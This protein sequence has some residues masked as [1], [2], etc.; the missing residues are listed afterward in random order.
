[1]VQNPA[2]LMISSLRDQKLRLKQPEPHVV[3]IHLHQTF[4]QPARL[5]QPCGRTDL[6]QT[7]RLVKLHQMHNTSFFLHI[8]PAVKAASPLPDRHR[9]PDGHIG[10]A[11]N[12]L[13]EIPSFSAHIYIYVHWQNAAV[14]QKIIICQDFLFRE[15][16]IAPA[17]QV[18]L[19]K[20]PAIAQDGH[21]PFHTLGITGLQFHIQLV[22]LEKKFHSLFFIDLDEKFLH[23]L[24]TPIVCRKRP[25]VLCI[26]GIVSG[27]NPGKARGIKQFHCLPPAALGQIR[28]MEQVFYGSHGRFRHGIFHR[29][30]K[31]QI[32]LPV[33][34]DNVKGSLYHIPFFQFFPVKTECN[35][36]LRTGELPGQTLHSKVR[37]PNRTIGKHSLGA[38]YAE[39]PL[40]SLPGVNGQ[41]Y[42][43]AGE[44]QGTVFIVKISLQYLIDYLL[45]LH[46][47]HLLIS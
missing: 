34:A 12:N 27:Q 21:F 29:R 46:D 43:C 36:L 37:G 8:L 24:L 20:S 32:V 38:G 33:I 13:S 11:E 44:I 45:L 31:G 2:R 10:A 5:L 1:M 25:V 41:I 16:K 40:I 28:K 23:S 22:F 26:S 42:F 47:L 14:S 17:F 35:L 9:N 15:Q 4:H 3:F 18:Q 19:G 30:H 7:E 39:T 6:P